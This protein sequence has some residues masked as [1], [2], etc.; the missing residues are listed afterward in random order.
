MINDMRW[1]ALALACAALLL[2]LLGGN[3][4]GD[5][6]N[7]NQ[8]PAERTET[9]AS[10]EE[11]PAVPEPNAA[12]ETPVTP[13]IE[14]GS[15]ALELTLVGAET[16]KP[17]ASEVHLYR[18]DIPANARWRAGDHLHAQFSIPVTGHRVD[19]LPAGRYRLDCAVQRASGTADREFEVLG[20]LTRHV[21]HVQA[22]R[23]DELWLHVTTPD[24]KPFGL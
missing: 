7:V 24:G 23:S 21:G 10:P 19:N 4:D 9:I 5:R 20:P 16:G 15:C 14:S 1:I 2:F 11:L 6:A 3:N 17:V 8:R 22:A 18:L 12:N 13:P